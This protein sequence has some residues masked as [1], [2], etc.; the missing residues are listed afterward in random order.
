MAFFPFEQIDTISPRAVLLIAGSNADTLFW[1]EQA[2][3]KCKDPKELYIVNGATHIDLYDRPQ[4]VS[5][6]VAKLAAFFRSQLGQGHG[7]K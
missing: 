5:P 3:Q 6:A 2:Y 4:F 7:P 1:S